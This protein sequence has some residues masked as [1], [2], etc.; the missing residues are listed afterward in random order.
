MFADYSPSAA[1]PV[2]PCARSPAEPREV[3]LVLPSHRGGSRGAETSAWGVAVP[4][5]HRVTGGAE[6]LLGTEELACLATG[7]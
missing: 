2:T 6:I 1:L 5:A 7:F 3:L 4:T